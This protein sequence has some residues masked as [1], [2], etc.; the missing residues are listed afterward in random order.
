MLKIQKLHKKEKM[1][2]QVVKEFFES[3]SCMGLVLTIAS[4][5]LGCL[6][7]KKLRLAVFNPMLVATVIS[8]AFVAIFKID[9][10]KYN[11]STK[12]LSFFLT[13]VTVCL[14]IPLYEQ[15]QK[16]KDNWA[17]VVGG[18]FAGTLANFVML[19]VCCLAFGLGHVEYISLLPKSITTAIG[20]ALSNQYGGIVGITVGSIVVAGITGNTFCEQI[21]KFFRITEPVAKGVAIGTCSHALGTTKALQIGEVEGAMSGLAIAVCGLMTVVFMTFFANLI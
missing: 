16:L 5:S 13:P 9:I 2:M 6:A 17:A 12:I 15:F 7:K 14:A 3:S 20:I 1:K 21:L 19:F 8:I 4:Y 10:Q 11:D 18:I